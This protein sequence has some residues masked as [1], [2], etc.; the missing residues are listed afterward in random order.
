MKLPAILLGLL[1]SSA[2]VHSSSALARIRDEMGWTTKKVP[3]NARS[4]GREGN[5]P[6]RFA[7]GFRS[8]V[9]LCFSSPA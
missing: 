8:P 5:M 9:T 3:S 6:Y 4:N 1:L 7:I 2:I